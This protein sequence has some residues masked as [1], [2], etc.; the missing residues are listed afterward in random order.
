MK[1]KAEGRIDNGG[2]ETVLSRTKAVLSFSFLLP[3]S[4]FLLCCGLA[5]APA[6]AQSY[7]TKPVRFVLPYPPG[8]GSDTIGRPLA[9]KLGEGLGQQFI[10]ENRG[11]ASGNI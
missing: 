2:R 7:P 8:G 9:Q 5:A 4:A 11:G 3:P 6:M 10:F 1:T